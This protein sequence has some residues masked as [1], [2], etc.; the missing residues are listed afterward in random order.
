MTIAP[1]DVIPPGCPATTVG[2]RGEYFANITVTGNPVLCR[3]DANPINFNWGSGSPGTGVPSNNFSARWTRTQS[4]VGGTYTF[5]MGADAG[6]RLYIDGVLV[7]NRWFDQ[8]YTTPVP[9]VAVQLTD[10][11]HTVIME[12]YEKTGSARATLT[13]SPGP[14]SCLLTGTTWLG[15][16]FAS[17]DLSGTPTMCRWDSAVNFDWAYGTPDPAVPSDNFSVRWTHTQS[18]ANRNYTFV[19][20]TDDGGRLYIDGVLVI[21]QWVDQSYPTPQPQFVKKM[22]ATTHTIVVEYYERGGAAKATVTIT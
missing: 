6:G 7:F 22:T 5:S 17:V 3:D 2:W 10:G 14:P 18:F 12:Y 11:N 21:D 8:S 19:L 1:K 20:G 13:W 4:F 15:Q 9:N 16:Y